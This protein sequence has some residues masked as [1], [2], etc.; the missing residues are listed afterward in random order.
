MR[1]GMGGDIRKNMRVRVG[2][3]DI[4]KNMRVGVGVGGDIRENTICFI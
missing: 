4:R 3:G 2:V 1:V